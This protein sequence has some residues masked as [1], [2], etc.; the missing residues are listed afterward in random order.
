VVAGLP[1]TALT[2]F[3]QS[4]KGNSQWQETYKLIKIQAATFSDWIVEL[5]ELAGESWPE[6]SDQAPTL[7]GLGWRRDAGASASHG[8]ADIA[9]E[10]RLTMRDIDK[11][12]R[13][14]RSM[15]WRFWLLV[16]AALCGIGGARGNGND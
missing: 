9:A 2:R 3:A 10:G 11:M 15:G 5:R 1:S 12:P 13:F 6:V 16:V 7:C 4:T 8:R 14:T